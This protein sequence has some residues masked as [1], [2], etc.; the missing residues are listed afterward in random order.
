MQKLRFV[1]LLLMLPL[2]AF[3]VSTNAQQGAGSSSGSPGGT[4]SAT[5][6]GKAEV[7][8]PGDPDGS[9]TAKITVAPDKGEVC[10]ELAVADIAPAAA[11]HIHEASADKAG[12][13]KVPLT[14]PKEGTSKGCASAA[15]ELIKAMMQNPSNYYVNVHNAEFKAGAVRGQLSK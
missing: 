5:L 10:F 12:P 4:L 15:P 3:G 8:G 9:G 2:V 6:S 1:A 14:A 7:P 11:A 13:V